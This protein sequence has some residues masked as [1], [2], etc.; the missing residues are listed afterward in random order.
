MVNLTATESPEARVWRARHVH[1]AFN[2]DIADCLS[3]ADQKIGLNY[4]AHVTCG[5]LDFALPDLGDGSAGRQHRDDMERTSRQ[6]SLAVTQLDAACERLDSG[7]LIRTV[8][9]GNHGALFQFLKVAGQSFVG[10]TL[11]G[12]Q[13]TVDQVDRCLASL[14][15]SA[16][17]RVGATS[18]LWGG[19]RD[20][21]DS[22]DLWQPYQPTSATIMS[23]PRVVTTTFGSVPDQ[24]ADACYGTLDF[25]DIHFVAIYRLGELVWRADLFDDR[26]LAPL[27]QRVTP[28]D[29]RR[30][31]NH[32]VHQVHLQDRRIRRLLAAVSSDKQVRLVLDLA[33]GAIYIL[34]LPDGQR[35]VAVTLFQPQV[36]VADRKVRQLHS[37]I[38]PALL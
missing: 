10:L 32:V 30:G 19:F 3:I 33:R 37:H 31:Y 23:K 17:R 28:D 34:P 26:G 2:E 16:A 11:D 14:A 1:D 18:L 8:I 25:D 12:H 21:E 15:S 5:V 22:P 13:T 29:R 20:R 27:F 7:V 9:Q 24:V 4:A 36:D 35:L 38:Q 6:L